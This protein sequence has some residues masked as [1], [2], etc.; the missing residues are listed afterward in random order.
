MQWV[1]KSA[2]KMN[3]YDIQQNMTKLTCSKTEKVQDKYKLAWNDEAKYKNNRKT[4]TYILTSISR[5][6]LS[7]PA[8][9]NTSGSVLSVRKGSQ[10]SSSTRVPG[11]CGC[12]KALANGS[13]VSWK[14]ENAES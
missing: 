2:Q 14:T 5:K 11:N 10:S 6:L 1:H 12:N 7:A 8:M 3:G 9:H 13:G 4:F